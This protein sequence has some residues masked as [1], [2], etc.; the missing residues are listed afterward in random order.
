MRDTL[1]LSQGYEPIAKITWQRAIILLY[2]QKA[3]VVST[4]DEWTVRSASMEFQVPSVIRNLFGVR[5]RKRDLKLSREN[6]YAR[7]NGSCQYCGIKVRRDNFT[8]DHVLPRT[9]GGLSTF[10]NLVVSCVSCNQYKGGR[11]PAQ[12]KMKLLS[13]PIK[14]TSLPEA[15]QCTFFYEPG[16]PE[17]WKSWIRSTEYWNTELSK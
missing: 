12:A 8:Y 1:M 15:M 14:P 11:T 3:E 6:I 17:A 2:S 9:Q 5:K 7:D 13:I 4:Y 16:M 10:N